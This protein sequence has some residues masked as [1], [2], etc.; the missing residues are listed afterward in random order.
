[1]IVKTLKEI[2]GTEREVSSKNW[3]SRRLLLDQ[4]GMGFS[5]HITTIY[6]GTETEIHYMNHLEAVYCISGE[7]EVELC[8]DGSIHPIKPG[9]VYAL[10]LHDKHLLRAKSEMQMACVFNPACTGK[11]IHDENGAYP[12]PASKG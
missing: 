8:D 12:L 11:E 9:T 4:E 5:F 1:M 3:K 10:N 6:A 2:E 7:G